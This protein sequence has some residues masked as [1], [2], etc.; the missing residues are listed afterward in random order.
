MNTKRLFWKIVDHI[1]QEIQSGR[2]V[3]GDRLP[4]ERMLAEQFEVSR[5]TV[6]AAIIALEV[7]GVVEV[8]TNSGVFVLQQT[9][10]RIGLEQDNNGMSQACSLI[11]GQVA[12]LAA[13]NITD[14]ELNKLA[15]L[16]TKME[17]RD[18]INNA[19]AEF[20]RAIVKATHNNALSIVISDFARRH[21]TDHINI[22]KIDENKTLYIALKQR[23][24]NL[25][26]Q[27]M[28]AYHQ[29]Q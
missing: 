27:A 23:N 11:Q 8:R 17:N 19:D 1:E 10:S 24:P 25:A 15:T 12:A 13:N 18:D 20:H 9:P 16:L 6:R 28:Q 7:R 5:P 22:P 26:R 3:T 2:Y 14:H 4:S 29:S 21:Q